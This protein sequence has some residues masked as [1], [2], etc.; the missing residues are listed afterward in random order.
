MN[1]LVK[2]SPYSKLNFQ[3]KKFFTQNWCNITLTFYLLS[4]TL[5][6]YSNICLLK[7][8]GL[9]ETSPVTH[10][11][12]SPVTKGSVGKLVPNTLCKVKFYSFH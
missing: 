3:G 12:S 6:D 10:V 5:S 1:R 7:G 4:F 2:V 11:D 8:Y 9:T